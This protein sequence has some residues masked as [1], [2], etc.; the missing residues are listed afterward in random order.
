MEV[1][2]LLNEG[3]GGFNPCFNGYSTL[4]D[5]RFIDPSRWDSGFNPCF[6]GYSTLT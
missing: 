5:T 1:R 2:R 3:I 4:T 6:N